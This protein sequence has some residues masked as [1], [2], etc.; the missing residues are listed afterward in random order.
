MSAATTSTRRQRSPAQERALKLFVV[1]LRAADA[2]NRRANRDIARHGL[3]ATEFSILEAL[4]HKG[5]LLLGEVQ[6]KILLTSGGVTYTVDRLVE[7]GYVERRECD[8][9]RRAR[10]AALTPKGEALM[11][12]IFPEHARAIEESMTALS[13]REQEQAT[14]LLRTLGLASAN[15]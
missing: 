2:V 7:K 13:A 4:Y 1:L 8:F 3:T 12:R 5:Q 9:D 14:E 15:D 10:Y 6:R 11:E